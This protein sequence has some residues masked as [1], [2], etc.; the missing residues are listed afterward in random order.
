MSTA[1]FYAADALLAA[2]GLLLLRPLIRRYTHGSVLLPPGPKPK[3]LL[4]NLFDVPTGRSWLGWTKHARKY[5]GMS[6]L[7]VFGTHIIA[8]HDPAATAALFEKRSAVFSDRPR[9]VFGMS[10]HFL[11]TVLALI[12]LVCRRRDVRVGEY[13]RIAAVRRSFQAL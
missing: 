13:T 3:F 2:L 4:G 10:I 9:L 1:L 7:S 11:F 12:R 5:G 8:L 6:H